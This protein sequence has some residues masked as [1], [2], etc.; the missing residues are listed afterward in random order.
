M[1][2]LKDPRR[3]SLGIRAH[4]EALV[5]YLST[6]LP[7]DGA[8]TVL[9][10]WGV[11]LISRDGRSLAY[12]SGPTSNNRQTISSLT[13]HGTTAAERQLAAAIRTWDELGRPGP[14]QLI[15]E[16]AYD[17]TLPRLRARWLPRNG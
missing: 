8:V 1:V 14:E 16:V 4:A 9:P 3:R 15:V 11:G 7:L 12:V 13:A 10:E 17:G 6:A 2:S 5:L